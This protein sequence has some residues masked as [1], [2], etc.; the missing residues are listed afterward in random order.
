[1]PWYR[2]PFD[3][4][5][6]FSAASIL[7]AQTGEY[8]F[9]DEPEFGLAD[10]LSRGFLTA[11]M[12]FA[13][14]KYTINKH[15]PAAWRMQRHL[16]KDIETLNKLSEIERSITAKQ[17]AVSRQSPSEISSDVT[18]SLKES[19]DAMVGSLTIR[20]KKTISDKYPALLYEL[21]TGWTEILHTKERKMWALIKDYMVGE[22]TARETK[23]SIDDILVM[24]I[25]EIVQLGN[26]F[27]QSLPHILNA[28][29]ITNLDPTSKDQFKE[30]VKNIAKKW[31]KSGIIDYY[32]NN[33]P[34]EEFKKL[35]KLTVHPLFRR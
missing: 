21:K 27:D 2:T 19:F 3:K 4:T 33:I 22:K 35:K 1:M 32:N 20:N 10:S 25:A 5:F 11:G 9:P 14:A 15:T 16:L 31:I 30:A 13:I 24:S 17:E 26:K 34:E 12:F 18:N 6:M 29:H 23:H 8:F 7:I 28:R